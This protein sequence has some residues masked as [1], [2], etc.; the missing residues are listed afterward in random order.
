MKKILSSAVM[1]LAVIFASSAFAQDVKPLKSPG[2]TA[3]TAE[4][5]KKGASPKKKI[6]KAAPEKTMYRE[7]TRK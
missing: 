2:K 7:K 5:G 6:C 3:K 1:A 4:K